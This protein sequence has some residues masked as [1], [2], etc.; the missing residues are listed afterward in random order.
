MSENGYVDASNILNKIRALRESQE[1]E[2]VN[3]SSE[4]VPYTQEDE[5]YA[6]MLQ[7]CKTQFGANFS[8][9]ESPMLYYPSSGEAVIFGEIPKLGEAKFQFRSKD[10]SGNGCYLFLTPVQLTDDNIR[11]MNTVLGVYKNWREEL[12]KND[13][14]R[15]MSVKNKD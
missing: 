11:T 8:N 12:L 10:S 4:A 3:E 13:D 2:N 9:T 15:P 7:T 5:Q 6:T 1:N 14:N